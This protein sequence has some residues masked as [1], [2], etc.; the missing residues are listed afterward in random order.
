MLSLQNIISLVFVVALIF[1]S[2]SY[3]IIK[4]KHEKDPVFT[5]RMRE[6]Q[7][8]IRRQRE[9]DA[10]LE[11]YMQM[12]TSLEGYEENSYEDVSTETGEM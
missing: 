2:I 10:S 9:A 4:D 11:Q 7:A 6:R 12:D 8:E 1:C 3:K 5:E